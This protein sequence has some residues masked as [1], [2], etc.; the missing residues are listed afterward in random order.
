MRLLEFFLS[1]GTSNTSP[2]AKLPSE[3]RIGQ[4]CPG[5][6]LEFDFGMKGYLMSMLV[7]GRFL[8]IATNV[9]GLLPGWLLCSVRPATELG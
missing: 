9:D 5:L 2:H 4:K 8:A 7:K 6:S 1:H 3:S